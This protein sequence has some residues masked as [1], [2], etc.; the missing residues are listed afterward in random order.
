MWIAYP[1]TEAEWVTLSGTKAEFSPDH[2]EL[3]LC[4][5]IEMRKLPESA[6]AL[7]AQTLFG[8]GSGAS[9]THVTTAPVKE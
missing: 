6:S 8:L 1:E 3:C 7:G 5:V 9:A 2:E 4:D